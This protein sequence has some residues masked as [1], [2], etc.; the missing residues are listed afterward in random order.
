MLKIEFNPKYVTIPIDE[1]VAAYKAKYTTKEILMLVANKLDSVQ[2][3][4]YRLALN[5]KDKP[6]FQIYRNDLMEVRYDVRPAGKMEDWFFNAS[7][8][9]RHDDKIIRTQ[10]IR[11]VI[12]NIRKHESPETIIDNRPLGMRL[13][14]LEYN[15]NTLENILVLGYH[16][17]PDYYAEYKPE[18]IKGIDV[19]EPL[20]GKT[21]KGYIWRRLINRNYLPVKAHTQ[22]IIPT[23]TY[24]LDNNYNLQIVE[25]CA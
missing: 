12:D 4:I 3:A 23:S 16:V 18:P 14:T 24:R 15:L 22:Q 9:G 10:R 19:N 20:I 17:L 5:I 7:K 2:K 6:G 1:T 25:Y 13:N 21:L 8:P 11:N